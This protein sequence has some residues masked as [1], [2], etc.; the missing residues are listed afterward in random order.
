[1]EIVIR[2]PPS[3]Q[4]IQHLVRKGISP[5]V[6]R[7]LTGRGM[8][9]EE[10]DRFLFGGLGN[11]HSP[12]LIKDMDKG[13]EIIRNSI[14]EEKRIVIYGDYDTDGVTGTAILM[15]GL[16]ELGGNVC[17]RLPDRH[18][19]G[20]GM[21]PEVVKRLKEDGAEIILTVDNG[22]RAH[23]AIQV[24]KSLGLTVVVI[25]HHEPSDTLPEADAVININR[26]DDLYPDKG[27]SGAGTA[28]KFMQV[29]YEK[30]GWPM[31]EAEKF[32]DLVAIST[33]ADMMPLMGENRILV[34]EGIFYMNLPG[35]DR[36]GILALKELLGLTVIEENQ[37]AFQIVPIL[38][39]TGRLYIADK[40]LSLLLEQDHDQAF[41]RAKELVKINEERKKMTDEATE[42]AIFRIETYMKDDP[43]Y[44]LLD[45]QIPEGIVGLVAGR[46]TEKYQKMS[47]V[48]TEVDGIYKASCRAP[49]G[50]HILRALEVC[51]DLL[52]I[53]GEPTYGGHRGAAGC[54]MPAEKERFEA[55]RRRLIAHVGGKK[56]EAQKVEVDG[57]LP[58]EKITDVWE[59]LRML[60]P[61]GQGN[62]AP[63]FLFLDVEA[64]SATYGHYKMI[65][66]NKKHLKIFTPVP[67]LAWNYAE[68]Y[69]RMGFPK[70][71][72]ILGT[73]EEE[74]FMGERKP[75][76]EAKTLLPKE[77][78]LPREAQQNHWV[79][80]M[81]EASS[82]M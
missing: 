70:R 43:I 81:I 26:R 42:R 66:K 20:Y 62:P 25:D 44:I 55:L 36:V 56:T 74:V 30:M 21:H 53:N 23:H 69:K 46:I 12:Y 16:T 77:M 60:K 80:W 8:D 78:E 52:R 61:F 41:K 79:N 7:I 47:I 49:E 9:E 13:T 4:K 5:F 67:T 33:I 24:A 82:R 10:I 51:D 1:M 57:I 72:S 48:F 28:F 15:E 58:M 38:N 3:A 63:L 27:L 76:I 29:L 17:Y 59:D 32:L 75:F 54:S 11:L 18:K 37:I 6:A 19:E 34:K 64:E 2:R 50:E 14:V 68:E 31:E 65:G 39:A 35:Y 45:R 71:L 40:A 73:I 22:I